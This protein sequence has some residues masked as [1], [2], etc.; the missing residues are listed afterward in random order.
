[1]L[2]TEGV[3]LL[4]CAV[5][6]SQEWARADI[7]RWAVDGGAGGVGPH[8]C[9]VYVMVEPLERAGVELLGWY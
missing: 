8:I 6:S 2:R 3:A 7:V 9:M 4:A 5:T 1:M